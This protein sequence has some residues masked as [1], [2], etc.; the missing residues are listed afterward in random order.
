MCDLIGAAY[1]QY[2]VCYFTSWGDLTA[3]EL[4]MSLCSHVM[5]AFVSLDPVG[6][7]VGSDDAN[8]KNLWVDLYID[9]GWLLNWYTNIKIS[10]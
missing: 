8:I 4:D 7:I 3:G 1:G 2:R 9:C 10:K 5:Y 6:Q